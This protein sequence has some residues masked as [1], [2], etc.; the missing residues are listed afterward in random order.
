MVR[1]TGRELVAAAGCTAVALVPWA[2]AG[3]PN[4][5]AV[6]AGALCAGLLL[7]IRAVALVFVV[8]VATAAG[9]F[10][11]LMVNPPPA[12]DTGEGGGE[13]LFLYLCL[14][15]IP[16]LL[17]CVAAAGALMRWLVKL[18]NGTA[19]PATSPR[20]QAAV[21]WAA[22]AVVLAAASW[23]SEGLP[24][25]LGLPAIAWFAS[26]RRPDDDLSAQ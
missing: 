20:A 1:I 17:S 14:T 21:G 22:L 16:V 8:C 11:D 3:R 25:L 15:A 4:G 12:P 18:T 24:L 19:V 23:S 26:R 13:G 6:A 10:V 2:M 5:Y 7:G 9:V